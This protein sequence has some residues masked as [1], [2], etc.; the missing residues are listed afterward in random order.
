MN[1]RLLGYVAIISKGLR[2]MIRII[3]ESIKALKEFLLVF[4]Y[5]IFSLAISFYTASSSDMNLSFW[6]VWYET[7]TKLFG[8]N[9]EYKV[10]SNSLTTFFLFMVI[11]NIMIVVCLNILISM[12]T[13]IYAKI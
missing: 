3:I 9:P 12:V 11:T 6:E 5:M 8:E 1:I 10:V 2:V 4:Y 7:Y 13:D